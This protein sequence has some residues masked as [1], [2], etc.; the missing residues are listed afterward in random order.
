MLSRQLHKLLKL[1]N[2]ILTYSKSSNKFKNFERRK[3]TIEYFRHIHIIKECDLDRNLFIYDDGYFCWYY[4]SLYINLNDYNLLFLFKDK[5]NWN[6]INER[7]KKEISEKYCED[8]FKI[9][10]LINGEI[11]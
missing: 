6:I 2:R 8:Y 5:L 7:F 11:N 4:I 9:K 10:E 3:T 1:P